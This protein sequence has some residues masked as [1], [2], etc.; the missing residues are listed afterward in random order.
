MLTEN[1]SPTLWFKKEA[2]NAMLWLRV[3][4]L[5]FHIAIWNIKVNVVGLG[6]RDICSPA[7]ELLCSCCHYLS[8]HPTKE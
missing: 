6:A 8:Q 4:I 7:V 2:A 1:Q 3:H 5:D